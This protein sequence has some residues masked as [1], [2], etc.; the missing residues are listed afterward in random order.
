MRFSNYRRQIWIKF[1]INFI[2]KCTS[3]LQRLFVSLFEVSAF[4]VRRLI[5]L[6]RQGFL[7]PFQIT[8]TDEIFKNPKNDHYRNYSF[9]RF[10]FRCSFWSVLISASDDPDFGCGFIIYDVA[11]VSL[12]RNFMRLVFEAGN[13]SA[14]LS[15]NYGEKNYLKVMI[16]IFID[17]SIELTIYSKKTWKNVID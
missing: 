15:L 12:V 14:S 10:R 1:R 5:G 17:F 11:S 16:R 3:L 9:Q 4:E 13:L 8:S 2:C 6:E 7:A